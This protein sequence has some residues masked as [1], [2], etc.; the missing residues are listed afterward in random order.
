MVDF[1][2][3]KIN[4]ISDSVIL[5][6]LWN[7]IDDINLSGLLATKSNVIERCEKGYGVEP[8]EINKNLFLALKEGTI[9]RSLKTDILSRNGNK[10]KSQGDWYDIIKLKYS[11]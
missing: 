4:R 8:A 11:K 6:H 10:D 1:I 5:Q 9:T 2:K 3:V 7:S